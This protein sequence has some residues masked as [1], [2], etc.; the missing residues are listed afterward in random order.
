MLPINQLLSLRFDADLRSVLNYRYPN[1]TF[2]PLLNQNRIY[3]YIKSDD[4]KPFPPGLRMIS[5]TA[6]T[7][8]ATAY[9]SK[10][11]MISCNHGLQS[12]FL[13]NAT[14]HPE[15]CTAISLG[16]YFPSCGTSSG[17]TDS[18]DHLWVEERSL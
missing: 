11:V 7:R 4:V 15:G 10:G 17:D 14:S 9:Q 18:S 13:P 8:N 5:G 3:Y 6:M 12:K 16:I 2:Q 1:G